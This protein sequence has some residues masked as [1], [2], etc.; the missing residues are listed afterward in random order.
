MESN[1]LLILTYAN[2]TY[3]MYVLPFVHFALRNNPGAHVEILLEDERAFHADRAA[4]IELLHAFH[5]GRFTLRQSL[6]ARDAPHTA[7]GT[8]R[9][10]EQPQRTSSYVY[11]GDI[12]ILV[13]EDLLCIHLGLMRKHDLP[14]SNVIRKGSV[15]KGYPKLSGL[16]FAP[17]ALQ[18]PL[19]VP[20]M[21]LR[22]ENDEH[23][24]FQVMKN[25]GVMVPV[26]FAQRPVCGIH[27]SPNRDPG[28]RTSVP[29]ASSYAT[30]G[31]LRWPGAAYYAQFLQQAREEAYCR[32][33]PEFDL[34]AKLALL[35]VEG[36]AT[37]QLRKLHR[38]ASGS[39][40]DKRLLN[41][42]QPLKQAQVVADAA[43]ALDSGDLDRAAALAST[44]CLLWPQHPAAWE[45]HARVRFAQGAPD[46]AFEALMHLADLPGGTRLIERAGM[47]DAYARNVR[48]AGEVA[49]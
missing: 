14:F 46:I 12:D 18:Y 31:V 37:G 21:D 32:L 45:T 35:A 4:G 38:L 47:G 48:E 25:K 22:A 6:V 28:G 15:E 20:D 39:L 26:D 33:F 10:I 24:L 8:V 13:F 43:A 29:T 40:L 23:V 49:E 27:M 41:C 7:P 19:V 42:I 5:A 17:H 30:R 34:E 16:H 2:R 44:A 36:L 1:D 3:E 9:F 11:I